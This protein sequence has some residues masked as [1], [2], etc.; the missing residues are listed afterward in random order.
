MKREAFLAWDAL[1]QSSLD[2]K[3][4]SIIQGMRKKS[5][6]G[7]KEEDSEEILLYSGVNANQ[8]KAASHGLFV[9]LISFTSRE[10][11]AKVWH[12]GKTI[13]SKPTAVCTPRVVTYR[14]GTSLR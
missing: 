10:A 3:W 6:R 5:A 11:H 9:T 8:I 14:H 2:A 12:M 4:E 13:P 1:L 7:L